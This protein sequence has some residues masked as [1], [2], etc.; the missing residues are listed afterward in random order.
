MSDVVVHFDITPIGFLILSLIF[1]EFGVSGAI[2]EGSGKRICS[3]RDKR[4]W[5]QSEQIE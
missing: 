5:E 2:Q 1:S 3:E 4:G